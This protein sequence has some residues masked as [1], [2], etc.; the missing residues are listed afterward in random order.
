M[1]SGTLS[2]K[3]GMRRCSTNHGC[4]L[5]FI[6]RSHHCSG[7]SLSVTMEYENVVSKYVHRFASVVF[8]RANG[9]LTNVVCCTF[10]YF[11]QQVPLDHRYQT[12][13][14]TLDYLA[15]KVTD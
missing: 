4:S 14:Y 3:G 11:Y 10:G 12:A 6:Q 1:L 15:A 5:S 8:G 9:S 2:Y 7:C 13:G